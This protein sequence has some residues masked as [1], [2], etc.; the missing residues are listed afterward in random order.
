MIFSFGLF[1]LCYT[2][3]LIFQIKGTVVNP[4][5]FSLSRGQYEQ[6]LETVDRVLMQDKL[7]EDK[8]GDERLVLENILEESELNT[9]VST[10]SMDPA[11]RARMIAHNS[12]SRLH[13][14]SSPN[15]SISLTGWYNS[16]I[17]DS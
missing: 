10:L 8:K 11:L 14:S 13:N 1:A 6:M 4:I 2:H 15:Q 12:S 9:G 17:Y 3:M 5:K 7:S 16:F